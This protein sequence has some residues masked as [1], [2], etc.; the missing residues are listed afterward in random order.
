VSDER[1]VRA[2]ASLDGLSVGDAL[3]ERF[4][5]PG[6][7]GRVARRQLPS[8]PWAW[9]DDTAMAVAL[10]RI[11]AGGGV[12]QDLLAREFGRCYRRAPGRGYGPGMR[13]LLPRLARGE[14]WRELAAR[15]W[16]EQGSLGNG[17]AMRVAPLGAYFADDVAVA[18]AEAV[19]S[20]EVTHAHPEGIAGAVAV[21]VTAALAWQGRAGDR[22][23]E[24]VVAA[25]PPGRVG[26]GLRRALELGGATD[27]DRAAAELGSG[28]LARA[29]DTVPFAIWCAAHHLHDFELAIWTT[30]RGLG[31][32]DTT[33]AIVGG[34]VAA[35]R[36][37]EGI[38]RE[39][40]AAREPLPDV[41]SGPRAD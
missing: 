12:D 3:G 22:L 16:G 39:W 24:A 38:P 15:L 32:R 29:D 7:R 9:T 36:G 20:A 4:F 40:L 30:L 27:P 5:G 11:L 19:R 34:I 37:H 28:A 31:D 21:A 13:R 18:A 8:P 2:L 10:V 35:A 14:D 33:C 1:L 26:Q 6:G 17:A 41:L 23:I 25:V